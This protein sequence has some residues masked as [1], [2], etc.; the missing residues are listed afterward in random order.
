MDLQHDTFNFYITQKFTLQVLSQ[1]VFK[2]IDIKGV[3]VYVCVH[4]LP[5]CDISAS[6]HTFSTGASKLSPCCSGHFVNNNL[7][8][9]FKRRPADKL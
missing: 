4:M 5:Q 7:K 9:V 3:N 1:T 6:C 2:G 8:N